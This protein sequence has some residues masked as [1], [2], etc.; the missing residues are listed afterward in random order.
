MS[1]LVSRVTKCFDTGTRTILLGYMV[2]RSGSS[3]FEPLPGSS[4]H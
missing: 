2:T 3:G 1:T 4:G